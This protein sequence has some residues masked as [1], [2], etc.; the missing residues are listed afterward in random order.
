MKK[1][2]HGLK[3]WS[4]HAIFEFSAIRVTAFLLQDRH[5]LPHQNPTRLPLTEL[6]NVVSVFPRGN[7]IIAWHS[8]ADQQP[9]GD[10]LRQ[11]ASLL[12]GHASPILSSSNFLIDFNSSS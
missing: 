3:V 4:V 10:L 5:D 9:V 11:R 8:F 6:H 2:I 1:P 12:R 7:Q